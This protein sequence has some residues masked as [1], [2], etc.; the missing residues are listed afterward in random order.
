MPTLITG[1]FWRWKPVCEGMGVGEEGERR[2]RQLAN[3]ET[4]ADS[5]NIRILPGWA[6]ELKTLSRLTATG[7]RKV[8]VIGEYGIFNSFN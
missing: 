7:K 3:Q 8:E 2:Q 5:E 6:E 4:A 1:Y